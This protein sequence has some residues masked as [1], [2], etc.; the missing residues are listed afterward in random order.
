ME[1]YSYFF[2]VFIIVILFFIY[3]K[4]PAP[5]GSSKPTEG[6]V[7]TGIRTIKVISTTHLPELG[8]H[9]VL[10]DITQPDNPMAIIM[11]EEDIYNTENDGCSEGYSRLKVGGAY[12]VSDKPFAETHKHA[13]SG[14]F[15]YF[16]SRIS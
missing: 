8:K 16:A 15:K 11:H 14:E 5:T 12:S 13:K 7:F 3:F 9:Y 10:S 4:K 2:D 6:K 1:T